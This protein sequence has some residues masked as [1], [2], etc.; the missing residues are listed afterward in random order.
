MRIP[1]DVFVVLRFPRKWRFSQT[2]IQGNR[3]E[4]SGRFVDTGK[5]QIDTH[6]FVLLDPLDYSLGQR[7][8]ADGEIGGERDVNCAVEELIDDLVVLIGGEQIAGD[9]GEG[10]ILLFM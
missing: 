1:S 9:D 3:Y 6:I 10:K 7:C 4:V 5:R 2:W 8:R